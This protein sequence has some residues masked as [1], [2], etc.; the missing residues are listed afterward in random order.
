MKYFTK[1]AKKKKDIITPNETI[2]TATGAA[3][4][5]TAG[6]AAGIHGLTKTLSSLENSVNANKMNTGAFK[7]SNK[8]LNP[9]VADGSRAKA[10]GKLGGGLVAGAAAGYLGY[11]A[12]KA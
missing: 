1:Q 12:Y 2:A 10:L 11:K 6:G 4:G 9:L 3:V 5:A 7:L 8:W